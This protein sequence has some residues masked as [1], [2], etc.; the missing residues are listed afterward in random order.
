MSV[1][2]NAWLM[3]LVFWAN[4]SLAQTPQLLKLASLKPPKC[5][6]QLISLF[7]QLKRTTAVPAG[8]YSR[9]CFIFVIIYRFLAFHL[10]PFYTF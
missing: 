5:M 1:T 8:H 3:S 7:S 6:A 9:E 4:V 10:L 2:N